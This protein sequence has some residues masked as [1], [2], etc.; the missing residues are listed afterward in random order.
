VALRRGA[1][2]FS[3]PYRRRPI[4]TSGNNYNPAGYAFAVLFPY[5]TDGGNVL[6]AA[7]LGL[8]DAVGTG[9]RRRAKSG[10]AAISRSR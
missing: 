9:W 8:A 7:R 4:D 1:G 2:R 6:V 3:I 5:G 10:S